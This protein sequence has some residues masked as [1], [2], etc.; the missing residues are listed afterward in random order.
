MAWIFALALASQSFAAVSSFHFFD[1]TL[2]AHRCPGQTFAPE[3]GSPVYQA[4]LYGGKLGSPP[5]SNA[6]AYLVDYGLGVKDTAA[7]NGDRNA[8]MKRV[9]VDG[10][11]VANISA[12]SSMIRCR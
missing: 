8:Y 9:L 11:F 4:T 12:W 3:S 10:T 1:P 5:D 7:P 2:L 6:R